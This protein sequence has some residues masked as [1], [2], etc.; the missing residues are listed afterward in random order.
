MVLQALDGLSDRDAA[1]AVQDR[2]SWKVA[3]GLALTDRGF[4]YSVLTY[5]RTR[6]RA[7]RRPE[8]IF[9]AVRAVVEA[10]GVLANKTRRSHDSTIP[11]DPRRHRRHPGTVT[12]L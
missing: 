9:D 5:W 12:Q 7:S 6:L 2:I 10:T 3:A 8:R 1:R 4:D 11:D